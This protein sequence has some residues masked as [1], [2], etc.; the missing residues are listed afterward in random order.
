[1]IIFLWCI[2]WLVSVGMCIE[3][4]EQSG[5]IDTGVMSYIFAFIVLFFI[6]PV[7]TLVYIGR[8]IVK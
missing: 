7:I 1:M 5:D 4:R 6:W 2:G 3:S 8:I